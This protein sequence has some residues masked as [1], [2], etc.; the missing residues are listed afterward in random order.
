MYVTNSN[1]NSNTDWHLLLLSYSLTELLLKVL[2]LLILLL[3]SWLVKMFSQSKGA[4]WLKRRRKKKKRNSSSIPVITMNSPTV[5]L[6]N[7][8]GESG[9]TIFWMALINKTNSNDINILI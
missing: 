6:Y 9:D 7:I 1:T 8:E 4:G 2:K 5:N 3:V